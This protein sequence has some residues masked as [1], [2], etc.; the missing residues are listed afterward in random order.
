MR[1]AYALM[2]ALLCLTA[3]GHGALADYSW[4]KVSQ[5]LPAALEWDILGTGYQVV[6]HNDGTTDWGPND[7]IATV[8]GAGGSAVISYRWGT[9]LVTIIGVTV[10]PTSDY[11]F[12]LEMIGPPVTTAIRPPRM[13]TSSPLTPPNRP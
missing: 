5:D 1:Y 7:G 6:A 2:L 12:D 11:T 8:R 13:C 4:S 10:P 9:N 3:F